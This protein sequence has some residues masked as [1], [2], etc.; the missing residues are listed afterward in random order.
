VGHVKALLRIVAVS[1]VLVAPGFARAGETP[2]PGVT[3]CIAQYTQ[4]G[5]TGFAAKYGTGDAG[6]RACVQ[7]NGGTTTQ[8]GTNDLGK[9]IAAQ[10]CARESSEAGKRTCIQAKLAQA[11]ALLASCSASAGTSKSGLEQCLKQSLGIKP[12]TQGNTEKAALSA[13]AAEAKALGYDAFQQK[14]GRGKDGLA[15]CLR[16]RR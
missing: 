10:L 6:K 7:A 2:S 8:P 13:C 11:Q 16:A 15:A 9:A 14:Y 5:A 4:L 1:A 12:P 3:V